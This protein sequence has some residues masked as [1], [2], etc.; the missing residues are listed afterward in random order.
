MQRSV[1]QGRVNQGHNGRQTH[2][3]TD[4]D[5]TVPPPLGAPPGKYLDDQDGGQWRSRRVNAK[6]AMCAER[7]QA[8]PKPAGGRAREG[9]TTL[10]QCV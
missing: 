7:Y 1:I 3:E 5:V 10:R 9:Y 2:G 8:F 4:Q 6:E